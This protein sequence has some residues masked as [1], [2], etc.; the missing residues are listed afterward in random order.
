MFLFGLRVLFSIF[1]LTWCSRS[2][3]RDSS[4]GHSRLAVL[5][6]R[7]IFKRDEGRTFWVLRGRGASDS[8]NIESRQVVLLEVTVVYASGGEGAADSTSSSTSTSTRNLGVQDTR[9]L[10]P[11]QERAL[12]LLH[13][14]LRATFG[15][16]N[17][18]VQQPPQGQR[19]TRSR[20]RNIFRILAPLFRRRRFFFGRVSF[21]A[22]GVSSWECFVLNRHRR[23]SFLKHFFVQLTVVNSF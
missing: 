22:A 12:K 13:C 16:K 2:R 14:C 7:A 9:Y 5:V 1:S 6:V 17:C 11:V 19:N 4:G 8:S 10:V 3:D 20:A 23:F 18:F 15:S 21:F